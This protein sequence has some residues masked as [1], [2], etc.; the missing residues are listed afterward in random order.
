MPEP[1]IKDVSDTSFWIAHH[2][3]Q[4]TARPDALFKD[5]LAARLAGDRGRE[6]AEAMP[7]SL[8]TGWMV[9]I[10]TRIID[11]YI[12]AAIATGVDTVLNVGAGLDTRPYRMDLPASLHWIEADYPHIVGYK[13]DLLEDETPRCNLERVKIDLA[14]RSKRRVFLGTVS[15]HA[16]RMLVL[17]EGVIPYL[18]VEEAASLAD[19]LRQLAPIRYWIVDYFSPEA[20]A[21]RRR[22]QMGKQMQ[23]APFRFEP[24]DWHGFFREHGWEVKE[25]RYL[26]DVSDKLGRE[27]PLPAY[28][29]AGWAFWSFFMS[30]E[31]REE[32][33]RF[34][35]YALLKPANR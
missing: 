14:D 4:E 33:R 12:M 28:I 20:M 16:R 26:A 22:H 21:Y 35:G 3:A 9:V 29:R 5:P 8:M 15:A 17:T 23:N 31:R 27:M 25:M 32:L 30:E 1:L 24:A 18:S 13:K 11:D 7:A 10:R 34:A 6:I 19:D 2:R